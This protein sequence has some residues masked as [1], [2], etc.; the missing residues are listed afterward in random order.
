MAIGWL[1]VGII[2]LVT[3]VLTLAVSI[4]AKKID[5]SARILRERPVRERI[6]Y[7]SVKGSKRKAKTSKPSGGYSPPPPSP[8][9][10]VSSASMD[11]LTGPSPAAREELAKQRE[12]MDEVEESDEDFSKDFEEIPAYVKS[13]ISDDEI[14]AGFK[15]KEIVEL[16]SEETISEEA[17]LHTRDLTIQLP[18]NMCLE[19][20]FRLRITLAKT[21]EYSK[22]VSIKEVE[23]SKK[24][25]DYFALTAKKLGKD[26]LEANTQIEGLQEGSLTIR[27]ISTSDVATVAPLHRTVMFNPG[28]EEVVVEFYIAPKK[29]IPDPISILRVEFEQNYSVIRAIDLPIKIYKRQFDALFGINLSKWQKYALLIYGLLSTLI[30]VTVL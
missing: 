14:L 12:R 28:D 16:V 13:S 20:V 17:E 21:D 24:E 4:S 9:P 18:K 15:E 7:G 1:I 11:A 30:V 3:A 2:L 27:P 25:A 10:S 26:I 23:L 8:A 6:V 19:E 29:W 5:F 22:Q